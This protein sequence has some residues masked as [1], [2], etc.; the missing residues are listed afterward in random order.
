MPQII[1]SRYRV[2]E[3]DEDD[4]LLNDIADQ[5]L[6]VHVNKERD[7][8]SDALQAIIE[9]VEPGNVVEAEIQSETISQQDDTWKFLELEIVDETRF[10]F[11]ES[12][13]VHPSHVDELAQTANEAGE[14]T[15][16]TSISS[17]GEPIGLITVG[18]DQGDQFWNGLRMGT[19]THEFDIRNLEPID[20]PPYEVIYARTPN[21]EQL[22]MYHFAELGTRTAQAIISANTEGSMMS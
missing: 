16:R 12:A 13:G 4:I 6:P 10:H 11:L 19:N 8:Y 17:N 1:E 18:E 5:G 21:R 20:D 22:I 2:L 9:Q 3:I 14:E 15:V 7:D